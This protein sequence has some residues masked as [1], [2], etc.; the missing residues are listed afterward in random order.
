MHI[1]F[2]AEGEVNFKSLLYIPATAP[3]NQFDP[4]NESVHK[5]IKLY[6]RRVFIT[7]DFKDILPKYLS[8]IKG[9]VDSDDLPLNVSREMLQEHKT[10]KIIKKK[11]VRKAIAMFQQMA[12]SEDKK[13]YETF[14]KNYGTNVKLGV[15]ED[16]NNRTRLSKLLMFL[17]SK[18][19]E[20][21]S[22]D[23]YVERMKKGQEQ[24]YFLAGESK[25]TIQQSPLI[26]KLVKRGYEVLYMVDPIDEYTLG[27]M[28]KFDGKYKMTN[29]AR[30]NIKLDGEK[31]D[32]EKEKE[33]KQEFEPLLKYLK[34]KLGSKI[35]KAV[36]SKRLSNSPSAL[37]SG[38]H[39]WT[40][41]MERIQK[42]QALGDPNRERS[43]YQPKK[44]LEINV[45]HPIV[46]EL[47]KR[48][49]ANEEDTT[50]DDIVELMYDTA[51]LTSG[52]SLENPAQFAEKIIKM[53][54]LGL[55]LDANAAPEE[56]EEVEDAP[57]VVEPEVNE[58]EN[59]HDHSHSHEGHD[60]SHSHE[61]D[62]L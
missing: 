43:F 60:H 58:S 27:N 30:E 12:E 25:E 14:W 32:E 20:L 9:V 10:L 59:E 52:W 26:E 44:V 47:K 29:V 6:V 23:K 15:I 4:N 21:T 38:S 28:D 3:V 53:M 36:I 54:N 55:S 49:E 34:N 18:T 24:I 5:G 41:T 46:R 61:K 7:D 35:E 57:K 1:H 42:A 56:E 22:L 40:P 48:V 51:A 37:V 45:R 2:N 62:E 39:G 17:S 19:G 50:A 13:Q 11:L 16:S 33:V 8:F 31:E